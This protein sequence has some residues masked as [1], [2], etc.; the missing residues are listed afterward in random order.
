MRWIFAVLAAVT[1]TATA[2]TDGFVLEPLVGPAGD[3]LTSATADDCP[4]YI[5]ICGPVD[6]GGGG[7]TSLPIDVANGWNGADCRNTSMGGGDS[8]GDGLN[9]RCEFDVAH[10]FAPVLKFDP[11]DDTTRDEYYVVMPGSG[12]RIMIFYAFGYHRDHGY[13]FGLGSH[14]GDSEFLVFETFPPTDN[15]DPW[16]LSRAYLSAHRGETFAGNDVDS[17]V[18]VF[19]STLQTGWEGRPLIW[20]AKNKHANYV[21]QIA[22]DSGAGTLDDCDNN[23]VTGWFWVYENGNLGQSDSRTYDRAG[24]AVPSRSISNERECYWEWGHKFLGWQEWDG[25][26]S[27]SYHYLLSDFGFD[28]DEAHING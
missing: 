17:S 4:P 10:A 8:D 11:G 27:T 3:P 16:R 15:N 19:G 21:S 1:L 18:L 28:G 13:A 7:S 2:C 5:E 26:G 14:N 20:V 6:P 9:D 22:C 24:C 23:T 12:S 25:K